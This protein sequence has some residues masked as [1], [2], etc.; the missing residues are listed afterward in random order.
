ME[1]CNQYIS[2]T[3][4][5]RNFKLG[6]LIKKITL[7]KFKKKKK[8]KKKKT[9]YFLSYCP[10]A[11]LDIVNLIFQKQLHLGASDLDS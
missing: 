3:I 11:N 4:T 10:F 1:F 2:K 7:W 9:F 5:A 8:K 6:Q